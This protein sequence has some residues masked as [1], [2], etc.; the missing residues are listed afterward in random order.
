MEGVERERS[1]STSSVKR[2]RELE[3]EESVEMDVEDSRV[4]LR[5]ELEDFLMKDTNRFSKEAALYVLRR[6]RRLE[7]LL[8][9]SEN[10]VAEISGRLAGIEQ[11]KTSLSQKTG[12]Y[13]A[14]VSVVARPKIGKR[15]IQPK[16]VE[17]T[18]LVYPTE[19]T[20]T[21]EDT[22]KTLR[23]CLDPREEGWQIQRVRRIQKGGVV[24]E[25][26]TVKTA[27]KIKEV[28]TA[29]KKLR[30]QEPSRI[31]PKIQIFDVDRAL[32]EE[33]VKK[34][35]FKQNLEDCGFTAAEVQRDIIYAGQELGTGKR[36]S[37]TGSWSV[38]LR[39]VTNWCPEG[40]Y[41][42]IS[43]PAE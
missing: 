40:V 29:E 18:A 25:A 34:C 11:V 28:A 13:A 9:K 31:N 7:S 37:V 5:Q 39:S 14:A 2:R 19:E 17:K 30:C 32:S 1:G 6:Y 12:T 23:Q 22:L 36:T 20:M 27:Q 33:E 3:D 43:R 38:H 8:I 15:V 21:S 24:V 35:L 4:L 26:G 10:K 42:S 41:M 16:P